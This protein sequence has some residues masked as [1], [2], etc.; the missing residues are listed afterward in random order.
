MNKINIYD[1]CDEIFDILYDKFDLMPAEV[2]QGLLDDYLDDWLIANYGRGLN[3]S[4]RINESDREEELYRGSFGR[5]EDKIVDKLLTLKDPNTFWDDVRKFTKNIH[6]DRLIG[7]WQRLAEARYRYLTTGVYFE[8]VKTKGKKSLTEK[9]WRYKLK[10]GSMLRDAIE[11]A[12]D[13]FTEVIACI[14]FCYQEL[15][16]NGLIDED[17][18]QEWVDDLDM[19]DSDDA[20]GVDYELSNLYDLCDN[21]GVWIE[22]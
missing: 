16:E 21:I 15:E 9:M 6:S 1:D 17:D 20:D 8:S 19:L 12:E 3:E 2:V 18:C 4:I 22:L 14:Q 11:N 5:V 13:D 7:A 10:S